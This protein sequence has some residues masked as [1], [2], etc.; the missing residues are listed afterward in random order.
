MDA[1]VQL[2]V[3]REVPVGQAHRERAR[4][5]VVAGAAKFGGS[6]VVGELDRQCR[7]A[8]A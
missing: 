4:A 2:N 1:V 5:D 7:C 6:Y 8:E 3:Q